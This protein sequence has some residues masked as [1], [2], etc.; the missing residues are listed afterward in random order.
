MTIAPNRPR[1]SIRLP[2][3]QWGNRT[4]LLA[5]NMVYAFSIDVHFALAAPGHEGVVRPAPE[6]QASYHVLE[7]S[8]ADTADGE[9]H[10]LPALVVER[11]SYSFAMLS[12]G[13][14]NLALSLWMRDEQGRLQFGPAG[15]TSERVVLRCRGVIQASRD[16]HRLLLTGPA[17]ARGQ[18]RQPPFIGRTL[19]GTRFESSQPRHRWLTT[20]QLLGFGQITADYEN[21]EWS[22]LFSY[23]LYSAM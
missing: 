14:S 3:P 18:G 11:G 22:V 7:R 4:A 21:G 20:S 2:I 17:Y 23:D 5:R 12:S 19:V 15:S 9:S 1:P 13:A 8:S 6:L 10:S 16:L